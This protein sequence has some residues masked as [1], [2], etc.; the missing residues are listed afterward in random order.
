[1]GIF[2]LVEGI[3]NH[4]ILQIHRVRAAAENPLAYDLAFL[5]SGALLADITTMNTAASLTTIIL[6]SSRFD[7]IEQHL[8]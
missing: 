3:V 8:H 1:M 5:A 4:H 2:N 6:F 7:N